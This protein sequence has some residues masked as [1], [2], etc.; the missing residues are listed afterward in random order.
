M[1]ISYGAAGAIAYSASAGA[2]SV[3]P[4]YPSGI[5][6]NQMLVLVIGMKP[7]T[8]NS[9]S[10]TTPSGWTAV[11]STTGQGGYSTTLGA[12]TGNTNL[13][14]FVKDAVGT[15]S[16]S[17][18]VTLSTSNVS[19][20]IIIRLATTGPTAWSAD[21]VFGAVSSGGTSPSA[22]MGS[23]PG[24]T[25]GDFLISAMCIPTDVKTPSQFS[26]ESITATGLTVGAC[27][28]IG[29]PDS[30]TG[31]DI[32]GY[33]AYAAATAG[34]ASAAPVVGATAGGTT[35][36]VRGPVGLLRIRAALVLAPA[37]D[38]GI[39]DG[40]PAYGWESYG[41][42]DP[43]G[44]VDTLATQ[45]TSGT[46]YTQ[47]P[48]DGIGTADTAAIARSLVTTDS[49]GVVDSAV[50]SVGRTVAVTDAEGITDTRAY[51]QGKAVTDSEGIVDAPAFAR[52]IT[53]TDPEGT[54]DGFTIERAVI[55]TD[56]SGTSDSVLLES[57]WNRVFTDPQGTTDG[58]TFTASWV[59]GSTDAMGISD[60]ISIA[61]AKALTDSEGT[62]DAQ[63]V[64]RG[65]GL[66]VT[67]AEGTADGVTFATD[68]AFT[69][70]DTVGTV[71]GVSFAINQVTS[72]PLGVVD[73]AAT[74]LGSGMDLTYTGND[75]MGIT[76][77]SPHLGWEGS[78]TEGV[79]HTDTVSTVKASLTDTM[80]ITDGTPHFVIEG[81]GPPD[82]VSITDV[83]TISKFV[84]SAIIINVG[85]DM[86]IVEHGAGM[87]QYGLLE[88]ETTGVA[89]AVQVAKVAGPTQDDMGIR[90]TITTDWTPDA[91]FNITKAVLDPVSGGDAALVD[92]Q[93]GHAWTIEI[94]DTVGSTESWGLAFLNEAGDNIRYSYES[95][96][97]YEEVLIEFSTVPPVIEQVRLIL[98]RAMFGPR[99]RDEF[100]KRAMFVPQPTQAALLLYRDG[101]VVETDTLLSA[102]AQAADYIAGGGRDTILEADSWQAEVLEAAGYALEAV[103]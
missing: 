22:T 94:T 47:T 63:T 39:T 48:T 60:G 42:P 14:F 4:A 91:G 38:E 98:N 17:L 13:F 99:V 37:D 55:T 81:A 62:T 6:A 43:I 9:G 15:E 52:G 65:I 21:A 78:L 27:T 59:L 16:G 96:L 54:T 50:S 2:G 1:S 69:V 90:D 68:R 92:H 102:E 29:E 71:D 89:E 36:N 7:S 83:V 88:A 11:G 19:W 67:D 12:D 80:G 73:T 28:E 86:G 25:A 20:A 57:T 75:S 32:G 95:V 93:V 24:I 26:A 82:L 51:S 35:T 74:A 3:S 79:G 56:A 18:S 40:S 85:D 34:T 58:L 64:A 33:L 31:N 97:T 5:T 53:V 84:T 70:T 10:V 101:R 30:G 23:N 103:T 77:G 66:A 44:V 61:L 46:D 41:D 72:D 87:R 8:A 100:W 76:D 49:E 45:I